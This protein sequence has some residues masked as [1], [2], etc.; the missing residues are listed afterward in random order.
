MSVVMS[1]Q[2]QSNLET[3]PVDLLSGAPLSL[4][5]QILRDTRASVERNEAL[6]RWIN[7]IENSS[8]TSGRDGRGWREFIHEGHAE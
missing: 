2:T 5:D 4:E 8:S 1:D 6:D 3:Q 7:A